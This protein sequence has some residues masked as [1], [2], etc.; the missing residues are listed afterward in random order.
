MDTK[1]VIHIHGDEAEI[2]LWRELD[3][4]PAVV[5]RDVLAAHRRRESYDAHW[6][7]T[8]LIR[9]S[10][11]QS[12]HWIDDIEEEGYD[13]A[14]RND[15]YRIIPIDYDI[16][17]MVSKYRYDFNVVSSGDETQLL[18]SVA[19]HG[20]DGKRDIAHGPI[21]ETYEGNVGGGDGDG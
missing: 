11:I 6:L 9:C 3:A 17:E 5:L 10:A 20:S 18:A 1:A 2:R 14:D 21:D 8:Y 12:S 15:E 7:A 4:V 13:A 19:W 16:P